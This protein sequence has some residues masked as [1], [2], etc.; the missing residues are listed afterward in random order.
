MPEAGAAAAMKQALMI[1]IGAVFVMTAVLAPIEF[2]VSLLL[3]VFGLSIM[4]VNSSD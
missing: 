4:L 3:G 2:E 1:I